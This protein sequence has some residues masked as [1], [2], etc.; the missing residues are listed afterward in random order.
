MS[1]L[2]TFSLADRIVLFAC[3]N[4]DEIERIH[5]CFTIY[6]DDWRPRWVKNIYHKMMTM[7]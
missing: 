2:E 5:H 3:F 1:Q 4:F 6:L 7:A